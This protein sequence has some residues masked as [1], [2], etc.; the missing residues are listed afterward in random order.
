MNAMRHFTNPLLSF[1]LITAFELSVLP[2]QNSEGILAEV[3]ELLS[4]SSSLFSPDS[5]SEQQ[6]MDF[7]MELPPETDVIAHINVGPK[8]QATVPD[9]VGDS[10]AVGLD[11]HR[12]DLLWH[13]RT[14]EK[15]PQREREYIHRHSL[16]SPLPVIDVARSYYFNNTLVVYGQC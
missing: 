14:L 6:Q 7:Y 12:A 1:V 16:G 9:F 5:L 13:P 8:H 15:I 3:T 10:R 11:V 4:A 2:M